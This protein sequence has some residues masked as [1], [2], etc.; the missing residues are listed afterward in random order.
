[1]RTLLAH[2]L[3]GY[4]VFVTPWLGRWK[5]R[6]LKTKLAAG[7]AD[8]KIKADRQ[9]VLSQWL[10][11]ALVLG[12]AGVDA[13]YRAAIQ[14]L[15]PG[16]ASAAL[17]FLITFVPMIGLST[18]WFRHQGDRQFERIRKTAGTI[19]P[20]TAPE[21]AWFAG[22]S[23][24][25]GVSEELVFRAFLLCYLKTWLPALGLYGALAVSSVIFGLNHLYQ[26][27][28]GVLGT[29]M[30]GVVLGLLY[31]QFGGLL[32]PM[33][34]HALID[35]RIILILTPQR[36][37]TL[38]RDAVPVQPQDG[39]VAQPAQIVRNTMHDGLPTGV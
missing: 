17:P 23:V 25:A 35:L 7:I 9:G 4:I 30:I 14:L 38:A 12:I 11:V 18:V 29:T 15:K 32:V 39:Y 33:V 5:Y 1:M 26:G 37:Q 21:K 31:Y 8:A 2:L 6:Q 3:V 20:C 34:V 36:M 28:R 24:G 22:I 27:Y 13:R 19:L 10:R 16:Y